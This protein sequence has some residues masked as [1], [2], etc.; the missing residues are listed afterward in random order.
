MAWVLAGCSFANTKLSSPAWG[1]C[2]QGSLDAVV[3]A[4]ADIY[5]KTPRLAK[6]GFVARGAAAVAVAGGVA[7]AIRLR[8]HN[9]PPHQLAIRLAFHQQ[10][11][12]ELG[13]DDLLGGAGEEGLGEVLGRRGGYGSGMEDR[14]LL[15]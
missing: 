1:F 7:L 14:A 5:V 6:Q 15:D 10:A 4:I 3:D 2:V 8:F 11:A 13:G 9:H 12:D